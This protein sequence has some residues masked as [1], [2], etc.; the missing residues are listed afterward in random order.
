MSWGNSNI[1]K[2]ARRTAE[3]M[4]LLPAAGARQGEAEHSDLGII[5]YCCTSDATHAATAPT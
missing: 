5:I 2:C 4:L 3:L 1:G